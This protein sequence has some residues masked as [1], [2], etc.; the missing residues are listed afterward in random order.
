[1]QCLPVDDIE[2]K[3][4]LEAFKQKLPAAIDLLSQADCQELEI[5]GV[6]YEIVLCKYIFGLAICPVS[7]SP[8][9][10]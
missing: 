6:S 8:L 7:S 9:T 3:T 5:D 10:Y 2:W 4:K 1:M